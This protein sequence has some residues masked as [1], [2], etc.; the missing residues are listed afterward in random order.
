MDRKKLLFIFNP[1]AGK[2]LIKNHLLA[3]VDTFANKGYELTVHPTQGKA[4]AENLIS[5]IGKLYDK[6]I[7]CGGD[8]TLCEVV[9]GMMKNGLDIP[10]GYIPAG[11][12]N[13]FAQ[14]LKIPRN[15]RQAA[16][17]AVGEHAFPCDVG[18][19]NGDYF[20]Y[21]AAFGLF[22]DVA[23]QTNQNL[24]NMIG[25]AAYLLEGAKRLY[26]VPSY[27]IKV[28]VNGEVIK[29]DFVVG[30]VTNSTSVGGI[31][32]MTG[33][34]VELDDGK[35]EVTLIKTPQNPL[36]L[37]EI[38]TSVFTPITLDTQ[39]IYTFKADHIELS[40]DTEIPWT[41]DGEFGGNHKDVVID[42]HQKRL[43]FMVK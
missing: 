3:I 36:Q 14:S 34:D 21:V 19:F 20:I 28:S 26:D 25:H 4:D 12:T 31:R 22:T 33:K 37:N 9:T 1:K 40:C 11:S 13:D 24:K 32:T 7:C 27:Q 30:L 10:I 18:E 8:G 39:Y 42:N 41:L 35:F 2:G 43:T 23:Y 5:D 15:M 16:R 38:L 29:D 6:I 17:I